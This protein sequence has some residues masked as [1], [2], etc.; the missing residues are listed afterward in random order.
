MVEWERMV[1]DDELNRLIRYAQG[2]GISV[3]FKPYVPHTAVEADWSI[4]G[5]E[6]TVYVKKSTSKLSK[7]LS[8]IHELGHHKGFV[9]LGRRIP[10]KVEDALDSDAKRH[11]KIILDME[12]ADARHWESIYADTNCSFGLD[13]LQDQREFDLWQY[14]VYYRTG[15]FPTEKQKV[16]KRKE[17]RAR[18]RNKR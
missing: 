17:I 12:T 2:M 8:L 9:E 10:R 14:K 15:S 18:R 11:R 13:K 6:I 4:D 5:T 1:R 3:R 7:V 16:E